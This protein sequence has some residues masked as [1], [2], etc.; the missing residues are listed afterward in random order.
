MR[1]AVILLL[2]AA[3]RVVVGAAEWAGA[4]AQPS[5]TLLDLTPLLLQHE[6][7]HQQRLGSRPARRLQQ[8]DPEQQRDSAPPPIGDGRV[9]AYSAVD[10]EGRVQTYSADV[11]WGAQFN[12]GLSRFGVNASRAVCW[13]GRFDSKYGLSYFAPL[14]VA[15]SAPTYRTF[16]ADATADARGSS[17]AHQPAVMR[18]RLPAGT[19]SPGS[20]RPGGTLFYA[21]PFGSGGKLRQDVRTAE[22]EGGKPTRAPLPRWRA[23]S[24]AGRGSRAPAPRVV[25]FRLCQGGYQ[26]PAFCA[27]PPTTKCDWHAG[28]SFMRGALRFVPGRWHRI[29]LTVRLNDLG[30]R[31]GLVEVKLNG[32]RAI[33]WDQIMWR[34]AGDLFMDSIYFSV[35]FGGSDA[36]W[37]PRRDTHLLFRDIRLR[38][39]DPPSGRG[40]AALSVAGPQLYI[41]ANIT[42]P[43]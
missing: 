15:M 30:Q 8:D 14:I 13:R 26:L 7:Q 11:V 5:E 41:I 17:P 19:W 18:V 39:M 4:G 32:Q 20:E 33:Y 12:G 38:R 29:A 16:V 35:W 28:V 34:V 21:F 2:A 31:N 25:M 1:A 42:E 36:S 9:Q 37:A 23:A 40:A 24:L 22:G 6:Q 27:Q 43:P 3:A 10:E